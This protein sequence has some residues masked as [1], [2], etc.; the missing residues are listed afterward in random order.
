MVKVLGLDHVLQAKD[1]RPATYQLQVSG[2]LGLLRQEFLRNLGSWATSSLQGSKSSNISLKRQFKTKNEK[3]VFQNDRKISKSRSFKMINWQNFK[4]K[5]FIS[6][7]ACTVQDLYSFHLFQMSLHCWM[8]ISLFTMLD[9]QLTDACLVSPKHFVF[10]TTLNTAFWSDWRVDA[11]EPAAA[12]ITGC[13]ICHHIT[14]YF[15][16]NLCLHL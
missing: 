5:T 10:F 14:L 16:Q 15:C 13:S 6:K 8:M 9:N 2:W 4:N 12:L 1:H 11:S 3:S 7:A